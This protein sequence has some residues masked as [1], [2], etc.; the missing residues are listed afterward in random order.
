MKQ[1]DY[2]ADN[3]CYEHNQIVKNIG[4]ADVKKLLDTVIRENAGK[5]N[6]KKEQPFLHRQTPEGNSQSVLSI[7]PPDTVRSKPNIPENKR[8][9][10]HRDC[11]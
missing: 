2:G 9:G 10:D 3:H 4:P 7:K 11:Q 1:G 6:Q 5:R 8:N